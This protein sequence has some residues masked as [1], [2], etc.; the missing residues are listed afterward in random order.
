MPIASPIGYLDV[1]NATLRASQV[2][3]VSRLS[4]ANTATTQSFSV[5]ERFHVNKDS[6]DPVSITGNV[7]ASG[8][9]IGNLSISP[10]F[11]FASVS[12]VGNVTANVIQFANATTGFVTTA[13]VEIGGNISLTA[14]AQVKVGSNVLAE[15]TGPHGRDPKEVPIKK[16]PEIAFDASK[17]DGNDTTNTYTQAGYTVT[18]SS[19]LGK[20]WG[21]YR[22]F[23]HKAHASDEPGWATSTTSSLYDE[24]S[25]QATSNATLFDGNRGEYIDLK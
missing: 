19:Q 5:G 24:T 8:V 12:N 10:T 22:A 1:V 2:E 9:K 18:A 11:D 3:A 20:G 13:N 6:V 15:Y 16:Y 4:V 14:N 23:N 21:S 7:V 25:G 17:M